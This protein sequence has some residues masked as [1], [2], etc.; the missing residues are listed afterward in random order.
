LVSYLAGISLNTSNQNR[1]EKSDPHDTSLCCLMYASVG[2]IF[3]NSY[4]TR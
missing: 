2:A 3:E 1:H 4:F